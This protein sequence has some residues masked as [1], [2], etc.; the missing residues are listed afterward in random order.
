MKSKLFIAIFASAAIAGCATTGTSN[1]G[2][3]SEPEAKGPPPGMNAKGEVIDSSK[4]EAGHGK[5]VKGLGGW[6][7]EIT[8]KC[9]HT[10]FSK[11]KIGMPMGEVKDKMGKPSD[12]GS[13]MT[14]KAWI[15]FYFGSDR[16]RYELL[17]PN[18]GRLIFAGGGVGDWSSGHLTWIICNKHEVKYRK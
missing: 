8:G 6:E 1:S 12:E 4:I 10:K 3:S 9:A 14:G 11:L 16:Y 15:P 2:S 13:Y 5:Q 18:V 7:G 17:Y